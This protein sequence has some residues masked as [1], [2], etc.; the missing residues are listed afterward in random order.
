M[1]AEKVWGT[2][3]LH[4]NSC[5]EAQI[6]RYRLQSMRVWITKRRDNSPLF[7]YTLHSITHTQIV[8]TQIALK[9]TPSLAL[10][11][12][13]HDLRAQARRA[14]A[15]N[16]TAIQ[17]RRSSILYACVIY[18]YNNVHRI[19]FSKS[20]GGKHCNEWLST[21]SSIMLCQHGK[22]KSKIRPDQFSSFLP[23]CKLI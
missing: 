4:Q 6:D 23:L 22:S 14:T 10:Q 20:V 11:C 18:Y 5:E 17:F 12:W 2:C 3:R 13:L 9:I 21:S 8:T 1:E 7:M 15:Q 19:L 16:V